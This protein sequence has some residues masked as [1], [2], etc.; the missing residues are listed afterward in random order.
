MAIGSAKLMMESIEVASANTATVPIAMKVQI[1]VF[2]VRE[3][4]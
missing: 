3:K 4:D 2:S 1:L